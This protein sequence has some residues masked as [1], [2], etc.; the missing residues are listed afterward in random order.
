MFYKRDRKSGES[1]SEYVAS[2]RKLSENCNFGDG[3]N[4]YLRDS[5]V[6][7]LCLDIDWLLYGMY[8]EK[9]TGDVQ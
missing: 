5:N 2:L 7:I 1:V 4:S 9:I 8:Q 6:F 3:L